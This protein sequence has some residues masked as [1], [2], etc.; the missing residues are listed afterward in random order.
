MGA[1]G[2]WFKSLISHKRPSSNDPEKVGEK[3]KKKWRLWRSS[4][5]GFGFGSS[6]KNMKKGRDVASERSDSSTFVVDDELA[7]AMATVAIRAAPKDFML[8]KQEWSAIRIQSVFRGF[9][10]RRALR[11]LKAVV[12]LQA[13]FRGRKVRKQAA[14]TLRCMHA[15]VKVQARVRAMNVRMSPEG[16]AV[17]KLLDYYRRQAADPVK[18][19][20]EGWCN[21]PGTVDEVK[22]KIQM[23]QEAVIK[24]ERAMSYSFSAQ[25]R[26]AGSPKSRGRKIVNKSLLEQWMTVKPWESRLMEEEGTYYESPEITPLSMKTNDFVDEQIKAR[27]NGMTTT[28]FN[29]SLITSQSTLTSLSSTSSSECCTFDDSPESSTSYSCTSISQSV[30]FSSN[31]ILQEETRGRRTFNRPSYMNL[32]ESTRSKQR[33]CGY[34]MNMSGDCRSICSGSDPCANLWKGV[35]ATPERLSYQKRNFGKQQRLA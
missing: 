35:C 30:P 9:L 8:I 6:T 1:S 16:K 13:I 14:I 32:T 28:I 22:A 5:E 15:L 11:A 33:A 20:E 34:V 23:K 31:I 25:S 26:V 19:A 17:Q 12:R 10:A 3:S 24:R 18:Q 27:R 2:R 21:I 7:S 4:S 29:G